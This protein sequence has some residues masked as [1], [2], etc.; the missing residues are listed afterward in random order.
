VVFSGFIRHEITEI[1]LKLALSTIS[2]TKLVWFSGQAGKRTPLK[3]IIIKD[4]FIM[5]FP[6]FICPTRFDQS[7]MISEM[8]E[9]KR[10]QKDKNPM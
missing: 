10:S 6:A 5:K 9:F 7:L 8:K 2:Q 1:L 3:N 4:I